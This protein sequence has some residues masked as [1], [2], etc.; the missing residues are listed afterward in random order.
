MIPSTTPDNYIF[1][2]WGNSN[3]FYVIQHSVDLRS[4][5]SYIPAIEP[6]YD[7]VAQ[8]GFATNSDKFFL[9]LK[10][11][12]DALTG[13]FYGDDDLDGIINGVELLLGYSAITANGNS[14]GDLLTDRQELALGLDSDDSTDGVDSDGD[15]IADPIERLF[16][17]STTGLSDI[18]S[19]SMDDEWE[20]K[21]YL[22]ITVDDSGLDPDQDGLT[23]LQEFTNGTNPWAFD[24][25]SDTILDGIEV[26]N[27]LIP[28]VANPIHTR[29]N[30][31]WQFTT[32]LTDRFSEFSDRISQSETHT[33][34]LDKDGNVYA[35]G[36]NAAGQLAQG[37]GSAGIDLSVP[38]L[39][40]FSV[41]RSVAAGL[42]TSHVVTSTGAG[43]AAGNNYIGRLGDG[44]TP[45]FSNP[46]IV[47]QPVAVANISSI[48]RINSTHSQVSE[49][50]AGPNDQI[51]AWGIIGASN[52]S[53]PNY[54]GVPQGPLKGLQNMVSISTAPSSVSLSAGIKND[55]NLYMW[56]YNLGRALAK[57]GSESYQTGKSD[58]KDVNSPEPVSYAAVARSIDNTTTSHVAAIDES[59]ALWV[60]GQF[61]GALSYVE[62]EKQSEPIKVV[63]S[64]VRGVAIQELAPDSSIFRQK[65]GFYINDEGELYAFFWVIEEE[66]QQVSEIYET[67]FL[68]IQ[69]IPFPEEFVAIAEGEHAVFLL[70][71]TGG[72]YQYSASLDTYQYIHRWVSSG[73]QTGS[74]IKFMDGPLLEGA[75]VEVPVPDFY[76][77]ISD[78]NN[79]GINDLYARF[80][81][82]NPDVT[83]SNF[84]G[85]SDSVAINSGMNPTSWDNDE[86]GIPNAVEIAK[87]LNP[88]AK[89]SDGDG[90]L[91]NEEFYIFERLSN[92]ILPTESD[93]QGPSINLLSPSNATAL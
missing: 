40:Q 7:E 37:T 24:T 51:Y 69:K 41:S 90:M 46:T 34:A 91:D 10:Y 19:D 32:D 62:D 58:T 64:G 70:T 89:D 60:W 13:A 50:I 17:L 88:N 26:A 23:N 11:T 16:G 12:D 71:T 85:V 81:G 72:I 77:A 53:G 5:W 59:G 1:S 65:P 2:W 92:F 83:D 82:L 9:R 43:E 49:A 56:G 30:Y 52:Y 48:K 73:G 36:T 6:G 68:S 27:G 22:D 28:T 15:G 79:D 39:T 8:W 4:P 21:Y 20:L 63:D 31:T 3:R 80:I 87:G 33:L 93:S 18:D 74:N 35:W 67:G 45:T 66:F 61:N 25:D 38:S 78:S 47:E 86:D 29:N 42:D 76:G 44:T 54:T 57:A 55:G 14:D 75:M 84:D